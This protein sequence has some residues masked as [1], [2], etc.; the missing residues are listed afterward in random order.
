M[1]QTSPTERFFVA[2]PLPRTVQWAIATWAQQRK[3]EWPFAKWVHQAD[4]HLT[5]HFLGFATEEQRKRINEALTALVQEVAPFQ[6]AVKGIGTFGRPDQPRILWLGVKGEEER[7][8]QLQS[9]V[10]ERVSPLG[11][12]PEDRPYHPHI[13]VARKYRQSRFPY[14][15]LADL[16]LSPEIERPWSVNRVV[17]YQTHMGQTPMYEVVGRYLIE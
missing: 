16:S 3:Q 15:Q 5:L 12:K 13:T 17:L 9:Q 10:V 1:K 7:L 14:D 4:Y 2:L 8:L 11:F 6:L